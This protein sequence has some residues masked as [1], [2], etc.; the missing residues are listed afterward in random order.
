[1]AAAITLATGEGRYDFID[2]GIG[3]TLLC[4]LAAYYRPLAHRARG[5]DAVAK[6]L[7]FGAIAGLLLALVASPLIQHFVGTPSDCGELDEADCA[8]ARADPR[9]LYTWLIAGLVVALV[10]ALFWT[11]LPWRRSVAA[12]LRRAAGRLR[13][14]PTAVTPGRR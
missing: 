13:R 4:L 1:M 11:G 5:L 14:K 8:G 2:L 10:H 6:S 3:V 12:H 7:S 9:V